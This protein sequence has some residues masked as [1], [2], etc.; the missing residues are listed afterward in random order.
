MNDQI[1]VEAEQNNCH[2]TMGIS[3]KKKLKLV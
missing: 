1:D 3:M 2:A